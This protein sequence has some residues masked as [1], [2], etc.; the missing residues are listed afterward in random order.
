[1]SVCAVR[2]SRNGLAKNSRTSPVCTSLLEV[3]MSV[4][5]VRCSRNRLAKISRTSAVSWS[6]LRFLEQPLGCSRYWWAKISE[7]KWCQNWSF[8]GQKGSSMKPKWNLG[9]PQVGQTWRKVWPRTTSGTTCE[10]NSPPKRALVLFLGLFW[11]AF[12]NKIKSKNGAKIKC[13]WDGVLVAFWPHWGRMLGSI[14]ALVW[15]GRAKKGERVK[16]WRWARRWCETL[17]FEDRRGS[18][19]GKQRPKAEFWT[20]RRG[21]TVS[22]HILEAFW[23]IW[24]PKVTTIR[25]KNE[26]EN[27]SNNW[28]DTKRRKWVPKAHQSMSYAE[29]AG[30][31]GVYFWS[32][33]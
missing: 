7:T 2:C 21:G 17:I 29:C 10:I 23:H 27:W 6:L 16:Q 19:L 22:G 24:S 4:C 33:Q 26:I 5:D 15:P 14:W 32:I 28:D 11:E 3:F 8:W 31:L 13:V 9:G 25:D 1:M 30:P 12:S 20:S 18:K